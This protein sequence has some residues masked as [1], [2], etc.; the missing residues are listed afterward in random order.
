[1][2]HEV[3]PNPSF[4]IVSPS[5]NPYYLQPTPHTVSLQALQ[6]VLGCPP[7]FQRLSSQR[8]KNEG[9]NFLVMLHC[10]KGGFYYNQVDCLKN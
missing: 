10:N 2:L 3:Q 1:M 6:T 8:E 9:M 4:Y 5:K 7:M